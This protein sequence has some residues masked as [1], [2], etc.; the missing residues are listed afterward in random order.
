MQ[1][2]SDRAPR[3]GVSGP[4]RAR[5]VHLPRRGERPPAEPVVLP[6]DR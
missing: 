5:R 4:P 3:R 2:S 1:A 6:E